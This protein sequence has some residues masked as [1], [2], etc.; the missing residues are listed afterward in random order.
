[1]AQLVQN[2]TWFQLSS[3]FKSHE[4]KPCIRLHTQ[5]SLLEILSLLSPFL[6]LPFP[7]TLTSLSKREIFKQQQNMNTL[8]FSFLLSPFLFS[9]SLPSPTIGDATYNLFL[10]LHSV[11]VNGHITY[12]F[13][14]NEAWKVALIY[15]SPSTSTIWNFLETFSSSPFLPLLYGPYPYWFSPSLSPSILYPSTILLSSEL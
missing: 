1:M 5:Q 15:L 3:W 7:P 14:K 8:F 10:L 6:S 9:I 2:I 11:S 12:S 4:I 13:L